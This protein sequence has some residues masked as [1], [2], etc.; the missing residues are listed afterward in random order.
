MLH[1][2]R[3]KGGERAGS[4]TDV[5]V[6]RRRGLVPS[7][8]FLALAAR[9]TEV[10][11][12]TDVDLVDLRRAPGLLRH[13]VGTHGR[14]LFEDEPGRFNVFRV[15]AWKLHLDEMFLLRKHDRRF[16]RE[17]LDRLRA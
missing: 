5:G 8:R 3:A 6:L 11:K 15:H 17:G 2:S 10:L 4:D 12:M 13:Q 16:I 7:E 1:G 14:L 9:L